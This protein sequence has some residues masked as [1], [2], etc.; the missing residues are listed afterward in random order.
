MLN[1][2]KELIRIVNRK[3]IKIHKE[4]Q[5]RKYDLEECKLIQRPIELKN[6]LLLDCQLGFGDFLYF[7]GLA[8]KLANAGIRVSIGTMETA[9]AR[10]RGQAQ[11][12]EVYDITKD[13]L[14][15]E[16]FDLIFDL[17]YVNINFWEKRAA[18]LKRLNRY[19]I[20]CGDIVSKYNLF[21]EY[22]DISKFAHTSMRMGKIY[23]SIMGT[24]SIE[25]I[26][27]YFSLPEAEIAK[28]VVKS[29]LERFDKSDFVVYLNT[30][31]RD[32]DRCL[33]DGQI[34]EIV[35]AINLM[36]RVKCLLFS[37][38]NFDCKNII[39]MPRMDFESAATIIRRA[40]AIISPDTSIVHLGSA[41][42]IPTLAIFCGNDRDY[43]PQYPMKDVWG[44]LAPNS[45]IFSQDKEHTFQYLIPLDKVTPVSAI[46]P[47]EL[48]EEAGGFIKM[49]MKKREAKN[50][51]L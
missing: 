22:C 24:D 9:V 15:E 28:P 39:K 46:D 11:F 7:S 2:I 48:A 27:P 16:F 50:A 43:Y 6:V 36:P 13:D 19:A 49:L 12:A 33:S 51:S 47:K 37:N 4:R 30:L 35:S 1:E 25:A 20:A 32:E 34:G 41:F 3:R 38:A 29:M 21:Q 42:S 18:I 26:Y 10:Y 14:T 44:P 8:K 40:D 23:A 45:R 31:A 17:T 5:G